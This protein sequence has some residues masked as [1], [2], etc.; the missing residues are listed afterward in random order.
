MSPT[1]RRLNKP[2]RGQCRSSSVHLTLSY[3][4]DWIL[5]IWQEAVP[6]CV[7]LIN[8]N[9]LINNNIITEIY[10]QCILTGWVWNVTFMHNL[11]IDRKQLDI[12]L[13]ITIKSK[14][15]HL[16]SGV[17]GDKMYIFRTDRMSSSTLHCKIV[18]HNF[19]LDSKEP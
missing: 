13:S 15:L 16:N 10:S 5:S 19:F 9:S 17:R 12:L 1:N 14:Y 8:I 4:G 7:W 18:C 6:F 11:K 3:L 2:V